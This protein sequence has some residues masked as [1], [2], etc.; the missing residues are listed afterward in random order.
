MVVN[1]FTIHIRYPYGTLSKSLYPYM[2]YMRIESAMIWDPLGSLGAGSPPPPKT[3]MNKSKRGKTHGPYICRPNPLSGAHSTAQT[4]D[5]QA[6]RAGSAQTHRRSYPQ[7][8]EQLPAAI[9]A[10]LETHSSERE[11]SSRSTARDRRRA[12]G[13]CFY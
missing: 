9:D 7:P 4:E 13:V 2:L 6:R 1:A 5:R 3:K 12:A 11:K 8:T 10:Q